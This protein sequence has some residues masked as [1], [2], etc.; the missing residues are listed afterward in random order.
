MEEKE[1]EEL[2]NEFEGSHW[3]YRWIKMVAPYDELDENLEKTGN[4]KYEI[5]YALHEVYYDKDDKPFMWT[6]NPVKLWADDRA[7]LRQLFMRAMYASQKKVL[8]II[9]E[10][11]VELDEYMPDGEEVE[12]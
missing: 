8:Q 9:D 11:I 12:E 1:I 3:N 6:E 2:A 7:D 4:I 10:T 5:S